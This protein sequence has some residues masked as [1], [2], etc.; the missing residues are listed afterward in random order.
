MKRPKREHRLFRNYEG[1]RWP[2]EL[3]CKDC[4]AGREWWTEKLEG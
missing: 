2:K 4:T 3:Q 1:L